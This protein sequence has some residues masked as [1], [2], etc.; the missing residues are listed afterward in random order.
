MLKQAALNIGK[1]DL[2]VVPY[3]V[4]LRKDLY[5]TITSLLEEDVDI[6]REY[7]PRRLAKEV[8]KLMQEYSDEMQEQYS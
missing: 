2:D 6:L 3:V 5:D 1:N 7:M 4:S 8:K